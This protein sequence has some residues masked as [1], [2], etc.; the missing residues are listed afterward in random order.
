VFKEILMFCLPLLQVV[1]MDPLDSLLPSN[2]LTREILQ[3]N[4]ISL[5]YSAVLQVI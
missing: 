1:L 5:Y 2:E 3:V 4:L